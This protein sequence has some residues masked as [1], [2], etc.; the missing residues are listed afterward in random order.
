MLPA[1]SR[2]HPATCQN[3]SQSG[4]NAWYSTHSTIK[5]NGSM[6]SAVLFRILV[7]SG[8]S[9]LKIKHFDQYLRKSTSGSQQ[10]KN[11]VCCAKSETKPSSIILV[12][13]RRKE[14]ASNSLNDRTNGLVSDTATRVRFRSLNAQVMVRNQKRH[15]RDK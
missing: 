9:S 1:K 15:T 12:T 11:R 4:R 14:R 10:I 7:R 3:H 8:D 13:I 2:V 5:K 6:I